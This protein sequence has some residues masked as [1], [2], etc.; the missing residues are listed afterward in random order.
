MK[1]YKWYF[2]GQEIRFISS[3]DKLDKHVMTNRSRFNKPDAK[4]IIESEYTDINQSPTTGC[5]S[6]NSSASTPTQSTLPVGD[7]KTK[8]R[9]KAVQ[10]QSVSGNVDNV[11]APT[12]TVEDGPDLDLL[13]GTSNRVAL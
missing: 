2:E 4:I 5:A 7:K 11:S 10:L 13:N 12:P 8:T 1:M 6:C 3:E 9:S